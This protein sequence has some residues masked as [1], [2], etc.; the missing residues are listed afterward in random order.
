MQII[1]LC[2]YRQAEKR[3][4]VLSKQLFRSGTSIGANVRESLRAQSRADF[5]TKLTISL[6]E[7]E[8][9]SYW[10]E[11]LHESGILSDAEIDSIYGDCAELI[12]LLVAITKTL[13]EKE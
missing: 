10:L 6:K 1:R 8:E 13:K 12:R 4:F 11:L 7:A 2:Q 5:Y 9:S 3:E